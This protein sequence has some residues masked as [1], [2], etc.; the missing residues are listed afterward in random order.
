VFN[1]RVFWQRTTSNYNW[2]VPFIAVTARPR[3]SH[4]G[5]ARQRNPHRLGGVLRVHVLLEEKPGILDTGCDERGRTATTRPR[6][7]R[8]KHGGAKKSAAS[9]CGT[10][11]VLEL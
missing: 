6:E 11:S 7:N 9:L 4:R 2:Q 1:P 5:N 3:P 8:R 10:M